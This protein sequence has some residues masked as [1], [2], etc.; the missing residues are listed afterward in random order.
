MRYTSAVRYFAW[1]IALSV[2]MVASA[3][4]SLRL[5]TT[6]RPSYAPGESDSVEITVVLEDPELAVE[7]GVLFL[8]IVEN[9]AERNWP[10]AMHRLFAAGSESN[11]IFQR[12]FT[13]DELRAGLQTTLSFTL[14]QDAPQLRYALVVQLFRGRNTNPHR[15]RERD[16]IAL[17]AVG[18]RIEA[19]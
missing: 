9:N 8:N 5:E 6:L 16:R 7:G 10:Q 19:P 2:A 11:G 4:P 12:Y 1:F 13:G 3:Q 14:R 18:F 15:V 17:R